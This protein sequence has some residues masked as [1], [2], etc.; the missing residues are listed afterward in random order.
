MAD[1]ANG[2]EES[3]EIISAASSKPRPQLMKINMSKS[4]DSPLSISQSENPTSR[5]NSRGL[6]ICGSTLPLIFESER[7]SAL[8]AEIL[9][10]MKSIIVYRS[11]PA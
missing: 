5:G 8:F 9:Q 6:M 1:H 2:F 10:K 7:T 3:N 4:L 11:S